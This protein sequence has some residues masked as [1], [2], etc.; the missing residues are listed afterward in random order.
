[1]RI[2]IVGASGFIGSHIAARL[3]ADG[4]EIIGA[5]RDVRWARGRYPRITWVEA[6]FRKRVD[7]NLSGVDAVINCVGVLQDGGGDST[8]AAHVTGARALFDAC[9]R[10]GVRR[11]I[12][13]S[14]I[15]ADPEAGTAYARTKH[16]GDGEFMA[17]DLDW[18]VVKPSL[19]IARGVY[20]GTALVRGLAGIPFVTPL[21]ESRGRFRPIHMRDLCDAIV[22]LLAIDA[23]TKIV[24]EAAGPQQATLPEIVTAHRAWLGFGSSRIW[25]APKW[26][27]D[28]AFACGDLLGAFGVRTSLKSTARVQMAHDVGGDPQSLVTHLGLA[29]RPYEVALNAEPASVQD[30]WHARVYFVKPVARLMLAAFWIGTGIV[31]LASGRAE[32]MDLARQAG[33]GRLDAFAAD[34]GGAFDIAIGAALIVFAK[35]RKLILALMAVVTIAYMAALT[36]TLPHLWA[37]PLGRL[38]KLI[39][40]FALLAF[41]AAVEDER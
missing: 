27:A 26:L 2:L 39:P 41:V 15:G 1:M 30:R 3:L 31:C 6:D 11:V 23:P 25:I 33:L 34:F 12:Q 13:I 24:I 7:W 14:A 32:A 16:E 22:R 40:F 37:D 18:I 36:A 38:M 10:A 28:L 29:A 8:Q 5:G 4:Y 9:E 19:V 21:I 35:H 17:R 20:G